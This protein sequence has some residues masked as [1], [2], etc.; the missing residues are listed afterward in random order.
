MTTL[1]SIAYDILSSIDHLSMYDNPWQCDCRMVDFRLK[2]T[3]SNLFENDITCSQPNNFYGQKLIDINLEDLMSKCQE[4]TIVRFER[5]DNMTLYLGDTLHLVC[6]ASGIPTPE[7]TV[8]LP[9]G[10]IATVESVGRVTVWENGTIIVRNVTAVDAGLYA[11]VAV[12]PM[13]TT[14]AILYVNMVY[15]EPAIVRFEQRDSTSNPLIEGETLYLVC[16]ASGIPTPDITVILPSGLI[17]TVES[18][19]RVTVYLNGTIAIRNVTAA[20][21]GLYTCIARNLANST[22]ATLV[23]DLNAVPMATTVLTPIV[24]MTSPPSPSFFLPVLLGA[25]CGSAFGTAIIV[26]IILTVWC[27]RSSNQRPPEGPDSSVVLSN[28]NATTT[29]VNTNGQDLTGQAQPIS[30][31]LNV[32]NLLIV[33]HP[34]SPQSESDEDAQPPLRGTDSRQPGTSPSSDVTNPH[35]TQQP[36]SSESDLSY[37]DVESPLRVTNS[38][39]PDTSPSQDVTIPLLDMHVR[40][41]SSES[42]MY[43]DVETPPSDANPRQPDTSPS[44][45]VQGPA[46]LESELYEDV[47]PSPTG[48]VLRQTVTSLSSDVTNPHLVPRPASSESESSYEDVEPPLS[49]SDPTQP[50]TRL[51]PSPEV[52]HPL[53]APR[54]DSPQFQTY[55]DVQSPPSNPRQALEPHYSNNTSDEPSPLPTPHTA[56]PGRQEKHAY[57]PLLTTRNQPDSG[58][59]T[60]HPYQP[61]TRN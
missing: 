36:A 60:P 26:A 50:D 38:R 11:C 2:M 55:E 58:Q 44:S 59:D 61:L 31:P 30:P 23:V 13:G 7:I 20:D 19:G 34:D 5:V 51:S 1:P 25:T 29:T 12:S 32:D 35:L 56:N 8:T 24:I 9:S 42:E 41:A 17:A 52:S 48:A 28:T 37:T 57:Q 40:R 47:E 54:P 3:G 15:E 33:P 46:V 43:E 10:L 21:A 6:E 4:P 22:S 14:D 27:K 45:D 49:D 18:V 53:L 39:Q 16:E